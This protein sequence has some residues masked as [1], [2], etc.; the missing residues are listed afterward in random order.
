M[1]TLNAYTAYLCPRMTPSSRTRSPRS[2]KTASPRERAKALHTPPARGSRKA[3]EET[4][5]DR[6][7]ELPGEL[8]YRVA[9]QSRGPAELARIVDALQDAIDEVRGDASSEELRTAST[10]LAAAVEHAHRILM[11]LTVFAG[12]LEGIA[13]VVQG[14]E[15]VD[16]NDSS[17]MP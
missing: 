3:A 10:R 17:E 13:W 11:R 8:R 6:L 12:E 9:S 15:D 1:L 2:G 14:R 7:K 4:Y 5:V 16:G